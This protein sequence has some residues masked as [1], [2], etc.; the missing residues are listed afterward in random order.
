LFLAARFVLVTET[1]IMR[2]TLFSSRSMPLEGRYWHAGAETGLII[3]AFGTPTVFTALPMI[4]AFTCAAVTGLVFGFAPA[5][6]ASRL[7]PV[8]ALASE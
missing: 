6:K 7:D 8:V 5:M 3:Q 2:I 1:A 4:L